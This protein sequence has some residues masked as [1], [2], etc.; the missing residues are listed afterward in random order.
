[1]L[2]ALTA[3]AGCASAARLGTPAAVGDARGKGIKLAAACKDRDG[4]SDAAPPARI[5]GNSYYVGTCGIAVLL[6]ASPEGHILIDGATAEAVPS[7]LANIRALGFA[8][9]DVRLIVGS[10][11]HADHMGGFAALKTAT[12]AKIAVREPARPALTSGQP[13][14]DDPQFGLIPGMTPAT[15]DRIIT[16][17]EVVRVG[18]LRLTAVATPGHTSGSTSWTWQSCEAGDCKTL[19]YIDSL[20]AIARDGYRF[21]DH[22]ERV[23]PYYETF[24]RVEMLPCDI[25]VTPHPGQSKLFQRLSG[26]EKLIDRDACSRLVGVMRERLAARLAGEAKP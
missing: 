17:N 12:G 9:R 19:A 15:V 10:H 23:A 18:P 8:P 25:L 16:D 21:T 3:L 4:W 24:R 6:I 26:T 22:P 13:D 14:P 11:E 1:M 20:T 5:Y 2:A 7:I